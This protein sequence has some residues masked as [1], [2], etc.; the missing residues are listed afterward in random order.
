MNADG[1]GVTCCY[2]D[3]IKGAFETTRIVVNM[4][5]AGVFIEYPKSDGL[6]L[7]LVARSLFSLA[8]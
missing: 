8:D 2:N 4:L 5:Y 7:T 1:F 3:V 6:S